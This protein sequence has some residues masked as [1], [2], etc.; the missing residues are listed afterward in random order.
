MHSVHTSTPN[1]FP[2]IHS[3]IILPAT[4]T[5]FQRCIPF[6]PA[7][8]PTKRLKRKTFILPDLI[9]IQ[10]L[11]RDRW[12]RNFTGT[13]EI[14]CEGRSRLLSNPHMLQ[15]API[16]Q[17]YII[18]SPGHAMS[19]ASPVNPKLRLTMLYVSICLYKT[20]VVRVGGWEVV[21]RG[22]VERNGYS[23]NP[24]SH[25]WYH[26]IKRCTYGLIKPI[27]GGFQGLTTLKG[28][29]E[30]L[31]CRACGIGFGEV[32]TD[33]RAEGRWALLL[34]SRLPFPIYIFASSSESLD[35]RHNLQDIL[36]NAK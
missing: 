9:L 17:W 28:C 8:N 14:C 34:F 12:R 26:W 30:P 4:A 32:N 7:I 25:S 23:Q 29:I 1:F 2:K 35:E 18:M 21:G 16:T 10:G 20:L 13:W 22:D 31:T 27:G 5:V 33:W 3:N 6:F 24:R 15:L 11:R 19:R 36:I